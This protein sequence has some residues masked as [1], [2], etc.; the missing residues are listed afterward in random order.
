MAGTVRLRLGLLGL[1]LAA[2]CATPYAKLDG[3]LA[4]VRPVPAD[5]PSPVTVV[6]EGNRGTPPVNTSVVKGDDL[7]T[8]A[9]G[10]A[11]LTLRAGYEVIVE[12]G[13]DL[14]IENPSIFV[15]VG[16]LILKSIRRVTQAI[17]LNTRFVSAGV[18]GTRF[19]FEVSRDDVVRISVLEGIV[20]VTSRN[21]AWARVTIPAGQ[22]LVI[23][24]GVPPG[25]L[26]GL[27][28]EVS[29]ATTDRIATVEQATRYRFG[30]PWSRFKPL[31]Q[32]PVFFLPAAAVAAATVFVV[33][34][35]G[36]SHSG[37]VVID[38]PLRLGVP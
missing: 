34:N 11:L 12:P 16:K 23:R 1:G 15:R 27:S 6:H 2:G 24:D 21:A 18:E 35:S 3:V 17:R 8:G 36:G 33:I 14:S 32:K 4:G 30:E 9:N 22:V 31:W 28:S 26:Q 38:V 5:Q 19:V 20:F 10:V 13:T 29:R 37:T 25:N 7:Q